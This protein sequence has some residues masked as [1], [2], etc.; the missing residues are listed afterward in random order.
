MNKNPQ[1]YL[2]HILESIMAIEKYAEGQ[3]LQTFLVSERDQDAVI[4]RFE[5]IG[6]AVKNLSDEF[7][8]KNPKIPWQKIAGMRDVLIHEY[9]VV[10]IRAVWD[11]IQGDLPKLKKQIKEITDK[12]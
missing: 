5:I 11:T 7:K 8:N 12:L 2:R 1:I 4:R 3:T 10:D 6:E 9:F